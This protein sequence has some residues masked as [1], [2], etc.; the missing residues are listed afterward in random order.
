VLPS[1]PLPP[2]ATQLPA[3]VAYR[4]VLGAVCKSV[5]IGTVHH[6]AT[7]EIGGYYFQAGRARR[8]TGGD[9]GF[10]NRRRRGSGWAVGRERAGAYAE[11]GLGWG[12]VRGLG[13]CQARCPP[14]PARCR[15]GI[16]I[17]G[18]AQWRVALAQDVG[19]A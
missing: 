7:C 18:R 1:P 11:G 3:A 19:Q 15:I 13:A 5:R 14:L 17:D 2:P 16:S 10:S 12:R 8:G 6:M 9:G 4:T